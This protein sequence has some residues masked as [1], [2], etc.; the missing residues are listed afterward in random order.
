MNHVRDEQYDEEWMFK[1]INALVEQFPFT[2]KTDFVYLYINETPEQGDN[3]YSRLLGASEVIYDDVQF[4]LL[5]DELFRSF[6]R[7]RV[8]HGT[9]VSQG[10]VLKRI[11]GVVN[12]DWINVKEVESLFDQ[13]D[14]GEMLAEFYL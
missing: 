13:T 8:E 9:D 6:Y 11:K 2:K 12:M 1:R 4:R 10:S 7:Y 14:N 3:H 5:M